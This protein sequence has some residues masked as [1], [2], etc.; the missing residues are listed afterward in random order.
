ML[1]N[2]GRV[3]TLKSLSPLYSSNEQKPGLSW[4]LRLGS[5]NKGSKNRTFF[6]AESGEIDT[7]VFLLRNILLLHWN[8]RGCYWGRNIRIIASRAWEL[9]PAAGVNEPEPICRFLA[10]FKRLAEL[11]F[12]NRVCQLQCHLFYLCPH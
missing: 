5:N 7:F 9:V 8:Q 6:Y 4:T 3:C 10:R 12:L 2:D 1:E 11:A